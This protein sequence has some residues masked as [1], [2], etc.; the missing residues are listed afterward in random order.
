M[1]FS[2]LPKDISTCGQEE[3]GTVKPNNGRPEPQLPLENEVTFSD[4]LNVLALPSVLAN[5]NTLGLKLPMTTYYNISFTNNN[6]T[7]SKNNDQNH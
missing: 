5:V 4:Q 2:V 3:L 1:G 7:N 6:N